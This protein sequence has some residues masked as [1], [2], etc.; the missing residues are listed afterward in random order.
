M[1]VKVLND[2]YSSVSA[3]RVILVFVFIHCP[4]EV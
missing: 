3:K 4:F 2:E 1:G